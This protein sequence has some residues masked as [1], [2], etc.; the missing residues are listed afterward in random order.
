MSFDYIKALEAESI[1]IF[2]EVAAQFEK[3]V[4]LYSVGKDSSVLVHL[5]RKALPRAD[6]ISAPPR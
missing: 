3:P 1:Y 5:A 2:R 4:I 6:T